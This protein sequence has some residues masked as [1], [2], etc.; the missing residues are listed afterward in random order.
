M[1]AVELPSSYDI[2]TRGTLPTSTYGGR[3]SFSS[4][5]NRRY[6]TPRTHKGNSPSRGPQS[7]SPQKRAAIKTPSPLG[8]L[9]GEEERALGAR[10]IGSLQQ[11]QQPTARSSTSNNNSSSVTAVQ[12]V[13]AGAHYQK[14][15]HNS[16][17]SSKHRQPQQ[18]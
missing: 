13:A 8:P 3:P 15:R 7:A 12:S 11:Q 4:R 14:T 18:G 1:Q 9:G 6:A 16:N 17:S 10:G 2:A 5:T